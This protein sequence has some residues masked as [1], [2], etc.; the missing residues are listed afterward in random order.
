VAVAVPAVMS[1]YA[2]GAAAIALWLVVRFPSLGPNGVKGAFVAGFLALLGM[3][4]ALVL[5]DPVAAREPYGV[6]LALLLVILPALT[7]TFWSAAL[8]LRA[9]VALRP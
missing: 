3:Q 6:A 2:V 9:L 4:V 7:A 5:I 8:L 1:I